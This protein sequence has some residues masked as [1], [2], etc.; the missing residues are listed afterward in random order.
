MKRLSDKEYWNDGYRAAAGGRSSRSLSARLRAIVRNQPGSGMF[1]LLAPYREYLLWDV[2]YPGCLPR[3][4]GTKV[5]EIGSAPGRYLVQLH[6]EYGYD[7]WGIEYSEQ[8]AALNRRAFA[9]NGIDPNQVIHGDFLSPHIM[10][11]YE[12]F[13]DVVVSRGFIEHFSNAPDVIDRH[14]RLLK[15]GGSLVVGIPNLLGFNY[16]YTWLIDR[17]LLRMHNLHIMEPAAYRQLFRRSDLECLFCGHYGTFDLGIARA[18]RPGLRKVAA[19]A[20]HAAQLPLN[21]LL[22]ITLGTRG[23][24]TRTF[25]PLLLY[26]GRKRGTPAGASTGRKG[27]G[28]V[29]EDVV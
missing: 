3:R 17:E 4:P 14:I 12:G 29:L 13:F 26:I 25:S 22:R 1:R 19:R 7:P 18:R 27:P 28:R 2:I 15:E 6:R 10:E 9:D 21:A 24:E 16:L 5:V 23:A 8:G 20:A 11:R